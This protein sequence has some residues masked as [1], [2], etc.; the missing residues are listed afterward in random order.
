V[1]KLEGQ[2][3]MFPLCLFSQTFYAL[4]KILFLAVDDSAD[5]F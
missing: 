3:F 5:G 2:I 4:S 1:D